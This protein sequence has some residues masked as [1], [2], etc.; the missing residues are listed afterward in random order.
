M[1]TTPLYEIHRSL[2]ASM[3]EFAG[4]S[5]PISYTSIKQEHLAAR[6]DAGLF[7]VSHMGE[8]EVKGK[9]SLEFLNEVLTNDF[10]RLQPGGIRYSVLCNDDGYVLDDLLVYCFGEAHYGLVVNASN[11][12][13][14]FEWLNRHVT[15]DVEFRDIS[16]AIGLIALQ[17]PKAVAILETLGV[18]TQ[19]LGYYRF[20][21]ITIETMDILLSRTGYTGED[22]FELYCKAESCINLWTLLLA[23]GKVFGLLPV[24]LGA[25]DTLRIEAGMPLYGHE[26]SEKITPLEAGLGFCVKT[27]KPS[28]IGKHSLAK[29]VLRHRIGLV[30]KDRMIARQGDAV[31]AGGRCVGEVTSGTFS[32]SLDKAIAMALIDQSVEFDQF[33]VKGKR[34]GEF[35]RVTL[36]FYKR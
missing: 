10:T 4:Y 32:P 18:R 29:P 31:Y 13:R 8:F 3:H 6:H 22:G 30:G 20:E 16:D 33:V 36:P 12:D 14:D 9:G 1:K 23:H 17:G 26:L 25:R 27:D 28:F 7:D 21:L 15:G 11:R 34:E 35:D 19:D 24:G 2:G 5:M